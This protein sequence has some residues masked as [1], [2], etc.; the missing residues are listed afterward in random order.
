MGFRSSL[1]CLL[2]GLVLMS[3]VWI[4]G[5]DTVQDP[6]A[7]R[8]TRVGFQPVREPVIAVLAMRS[9]R[10]LLLDR[11]D[12]HTLQEVPLRSLSIDMDCSAERILTAQCGPPA[13]RSDTAI[14]VLDL[15]RGTR[16]YI[17]TGHLGP[18]RVV[19]VDGIW[20]FA[21]SSS[22]LDAGMGA[23]V[24]DLDEMKAT[25][26]T[27]PHGT[28]GFAA[29]RGRLWLAER[30]FGDGNETPTVHMYE[31][32]ADRSVRPLPLDARD[33]AAIADTGR[34]VVVVRWRPQ[35]PEIAGAE[36]Y[37]YEETLVRSV[38]LTGLAGE[39]VAVVG[40]G[41][42]GFAVL[43][44]RGE[45]GPGSLV[46]VSGTADAPSWTV[47]HI[48]GPVALASTN[49]AFVVGSRSTGEVRMIRATDGKVTLRRKVVAEAGD[50]ADVGYCAVR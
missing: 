14:G 21:L 10:V 16:R 32:G 15:A 37:S 29:I 48:D 42:G 26:L 28:R 36:L 4:T 22:V 6:M 19:D 50:L 47:A 18:E 24:L 49:D 38:E 8:E 35:H 27:V 23:D 25:G 46:F 3:A 17:E 33:V 30:W 20:A 5:C 41:A 31:F 12:L 9:P 43:S 11:R 45:D 40:D 13:E 7:V 39:P 1:R 2:P 44:A 34:G